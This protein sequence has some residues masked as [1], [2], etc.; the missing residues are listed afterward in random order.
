VVAAAERHAEAVEGPHQRVRPVPECVSV[1]GQELE[2]FGVIERMKMRCGAA[3]PDLIAF[4]R[5][6]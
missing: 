5:L 2:L 3:Q 6:D 4:C 1:S